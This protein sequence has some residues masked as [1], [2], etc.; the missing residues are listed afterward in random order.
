MRSA[1]ARAQGRAIV[2]SL[3]WVHC[4]KRTGF[5]ARTKISEVGSQLACQATTLG[6]SDPTASTVV[7]W[8][9]LVSEGGTNCVWS[10]GTHPHLEHLLR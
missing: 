7:S 8:A 4:T 3:I 1:T 10:D 2:V 5:W 9:A 6:S